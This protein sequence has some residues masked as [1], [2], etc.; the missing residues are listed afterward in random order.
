MPLAGEND[1]ETVMLAEGPPYGGT[2]TLTPRDPLS[3]TPAPR[4]IDQYLTPAQIALDHGLP[5][6]EPA[7]QIGCAHIWSP[8]KTAVSRD[9]HHRPVYGVECVNCKRKRVFSTRE[10]LAAYVAG[11]TSG[12]GLAPSYKEAR[13]LVQ[14]QG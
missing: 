12:F 8:R 6:T 3:E 14:E 5:E 11:Q 9:F 13:T 7:R 1:V 4:A 2:F 10:L